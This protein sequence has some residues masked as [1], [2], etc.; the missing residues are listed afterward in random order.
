M[1]V[2]GLK[3]KMTDLEYIKHECKDFP[4]KLCGAILLILIILYLIWGWWGVVG[5]IAVP[6]LFGLINFG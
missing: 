5:G 3:S 4:F 6:I 1:L 2:V